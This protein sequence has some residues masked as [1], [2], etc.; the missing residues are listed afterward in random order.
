MFVRGKSGDRS[1]WFVTDPGCVPVGPE[2]G[3]LVYHAGQF[4][5]VA[6]VQK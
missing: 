5:P 2:V 1:R 4:V 6:E 3:V